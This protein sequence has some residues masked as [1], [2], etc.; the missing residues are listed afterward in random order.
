[1][2]LGDTELLQQ[3][4]TNLVTNAIQAM[5]EG[6]TVTLATRPL[7]EGAIQVRVSDEGVGI[8]LD[9][10]DRIFRLY[11]TTKPNGS[12]IGLSIVYRIMQ[13]HD[14]RIDV[15]SEVGRGSSMILTLPTAPAQAIP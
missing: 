4:C 2:V 7:P 11:Y 10:L 13:M 9:E 1:M 8:P 15:E 6:G 5:P 12:G 3:A 14:G